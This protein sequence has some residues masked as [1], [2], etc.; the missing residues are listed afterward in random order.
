MR[1]PD[2]GQGM[3][4]NEQV[5]S[6]PQFERVLFKMGVAAL[7]LPHICGGIKRTAQMRKRSLDFTAGHGRRHGGGDAATGRQMGNAPPLIKLLRPLGWERADLP[8]RQ[9]AFW[10]FP[11][12]NY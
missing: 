6:T 1:W 9:G 12:K 7:Q 8:L 10:D 3:P 5:Q 4:V 11:E 2:I